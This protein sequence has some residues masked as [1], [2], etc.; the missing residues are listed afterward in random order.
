MEEPSPAPEP[1]DPTVAEGWRGAARRWL[2]G[3]WRGVGVAGAMLMVL[4]G[5]YLLRPRNSVAPRH[6]DRRLVVMTPH[7]E[8]IRRE[9]AA[10]F[11]RFWKK[12][13]GQSVYVDWRVPGGT[14]EIG[15]LLKSEYAAAFQQLWQGKMGQPWSDAVARSFL[16]RKVKPEDDAASE[17]KPEDDAEDD[18]N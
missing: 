12:R 6:Y 11:A 16:D 2:R 15:L 18:T 7:H 10:G 9:F 3:H 14:S 1:I 17:P 5:P 8:T 13:A 4:A